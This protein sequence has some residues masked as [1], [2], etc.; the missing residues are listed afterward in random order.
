VNVRYSVGVEGGSHDMVWDEAKVIEGGWLR[1][2]N[3]AKNEGGDGE[4]VIDERWYP[5]TSVYSVMPLRG[6]TSQTGG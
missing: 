5:P 3:Y 6:A 1:C 2:R 4:T